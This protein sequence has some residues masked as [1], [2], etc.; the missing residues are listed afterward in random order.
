MPKIDPHQSWLPL[1][2]RA[3]AEPDPHR[4]SLLTHVRDHMEHEIKGNLD[5]LME[6]LCASPVYHFWA[7]T[8]LSCVARRPFAIFTRA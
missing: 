1:E 4:R 5:A 2:A 8:S 7:Q 6:T 3:A